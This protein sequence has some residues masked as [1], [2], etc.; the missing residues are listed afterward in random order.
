MPDFPRDLCSTKIEYSHTLGEAF[1]LLKYFLMEETQ[2]WD[3][4]TT[5]VDLLI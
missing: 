1:S 4:N 5:D 3:I 2:M